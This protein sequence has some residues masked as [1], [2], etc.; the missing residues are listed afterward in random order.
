MTARLHETISTQMNF[1]T[2][3]RFVEFDEKDFYQSIFRHHSFQIQNERIA[4]KRL[5]RICDATFYLAN[6]G[7]FQSMTLRQLSEQSEMSMGGLYAYISSKEELAHLI[8]SS[9]N[10][11]CQEQMNHLIDTSE[12]AA[13]Q[14]QKVLRCHLHLS[15]LLQ[16]W[17]Y[18]AYMEAR[19]LNNQIQMAIESEMVMEDKITQLIKQG[20]KEGSFNLSSDNLSLNK[21]KLIRLNACLIKSMLQDWYL[22]KSKYQRRRISVDYYAD[23]LIA[24]TL[25]HLNFLPRES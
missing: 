1:K 3:C 15:E 22:K 4:I 5:K 23:E 16:P 6:H 2:F 14:L 17:F 13:T 21:A 19:S 12:D 10:R 11:Y 9:L 7:G 25:D 20:I 8:Y 24:M 18:F